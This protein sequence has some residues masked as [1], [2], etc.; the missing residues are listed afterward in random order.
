MR[1]LLACSGILFIAILLPYIFV[2]GCS[3][4]SDTISSPALSKSRGR[5]YHTISRP[6]PLQDHIQDNWTS[7]DTSATGGSH[8]AHIK[9]Y[10]HTYQNLASHSSAADFI[11]DHFDMF[12]W[13]GPIVET[14]A[15]NLNPTMVWLYE[16]GNIPSIRS[17]YDSLR[18]EAWRECP[19]HS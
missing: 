11:A 10:G 14:A 13:G 8:Y 16:A 6:N 1:R 5:P 9:L 18:V 15:D 3:D 19:I 4:N 12:M 17:G 2:T 7:G